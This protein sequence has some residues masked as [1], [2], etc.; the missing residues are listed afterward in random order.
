VDSRIT[1]GYL[2]DERDEKHHNIDKFCGDWV[3]AHDHYSY[4]PIQ[5]IIGMDWWMYEGGAPRKQADGSWL[6]MYT[7]HGRAAFNGQHQAS[8]KHLSET[9]RCY[10]PCTMERVDLLRH[11]HGAQF[12]RECRAGAA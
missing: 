6:I 7:F 11:F 2:T 10:A 4:Q 12:G 3:Q 8:Y 1:T 5:P 9:T